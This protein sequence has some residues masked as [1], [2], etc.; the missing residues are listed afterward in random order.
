[1]FINNIGDDSA[2]AIFTGVPLYYIPTTKEVV[3]YSP[4]GI[5]PSIILYKSSSQTFPTGVSPFTWNSVDHS[6]GGAGIAPTL[7]QSGVDIEINRAGLYL[8]TYDYT[9]HGLGTSGS[10]YQSF[11]SVNNNYNSA[12][13]GNVRI[14][15]ESA[16]SIRAFNGTA[17]IK[18]EIGDT[19]QLCGSFST[20]VIIPYS[21]A[22][23]ARCELTCT[24]I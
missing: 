7:S 24:A 21:G 8:I 17:V 2:D 22:E 16:Q 12:R 23:F 11:I 20:T 1:M 9:V 15:D 5:S 18:L 19:I 4:V 14:S 3:Q 6:Q 10:L 13:Y